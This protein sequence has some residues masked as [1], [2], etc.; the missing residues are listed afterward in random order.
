M[1]STIGNSDL[2]RREFVQISAGAAAIVAS[3]KAWSSTST[4]PTRDFEHGSPLSEFG[5]GDVQFAPGPHQ[6]QLEQTH[7]ILMGLDEDGLFRPFRMAAG[8][9]APGLDL[10]GWHSWPVLFGPESFGHWMS[11]LSRYYV[12]TGDAQTRAKVERWLQLF[13]AALDSKGSLFK[14][15]E[16]DACNV[17]NKLLC[18]LEDAYHF[19]GLPLALEA[20]ERMTTSAM[21]Y[22]PERAHEQDESHETQE[23]YIL[24]E[25]QFVAWQRGADSRH[26]QMARQYLFE[27]FFVSLAQGDNVLPGRHAYSHVN[28]LCSAAKAYLVLGEERYLKAAVNGFTFVEEQSWATGGWG[29]NEAFLPVPAAD[30]KD[31]DTGEQKHEP[32]LEFLGDALARSPYHF[33]TPCGSQAHFKLTRYLLRITKD[34]HYGDSMERLMYNTVLGALPINKFGAAFYHSNYHPHAHKEYFDGY[35]HALPSEWHC[36]SG[37]LPQVAAD[38]HISTYFKDAEGVFVNL[39]IP[40]TLRWRQHDADISLVQSGQYP[41]ADEVAFE[42]T[43]SQP[44]HFSVRL[45]IPA[46]SR[47]PSIRVNGKLIS[48]PVRSGTFASIHRRWHSG[49]RIELILPRELELK[50]VDPQHPDM[51]ALL[52]GPL[53]LFAISDDTPKVTRAQLLTARQQGNGNAEWHADS[54]GGPLRFKPFWVIKDETYFTYLSV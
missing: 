22:L 37:T 4:S 44:A 45:R 42:I 10:G 23:S 24:P 39:Y 14:E 7:S 49:D 16:K 31:P 25:Y 32:A 29:P 30:Y 50:P 34:P 47:A 12:I 19:A 41:L 20:L 15:H 26:L 28:S 11:A 33:E 13:S 1:D 27:E 21:P 43:T 17:Y 3:S 35:G 51:V 38:Y 52:S 9:A 18:G 54:V 6:S 36:C 5:Y 2:T 46:W 40:S 8:L 53:V 48:E